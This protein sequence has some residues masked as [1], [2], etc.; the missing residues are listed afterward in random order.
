MQNFEKWRA[1]EKRQK[2]RFSRFLDNLG[3]LYSIF[4]KVR[5]NLFQSY[6]STP[7]VVPYVKFSGQNSKNSA[8][9]GPLKI[10]QNAEKRWIM[11]VFLVCRK[12]H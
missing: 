10:T 6:E 9:T 8:Y 1:L 7:K 5:S 11:G 4:M 3:P 2:T 12:S